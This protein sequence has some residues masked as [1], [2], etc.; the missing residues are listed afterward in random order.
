[1]RRDHCQG[2]ELRIKQKLHLTT[3]RWRLPQL[4]GSTVWGTSYDFRTMVEAEAESESRFRECKASPILAKRSSYPDEWW[5]GI[6]WILSRR[7][8]EIAAI[9][10]F[11]P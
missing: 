6:H 1:M 3:A 10:G 5:Q 11:A 2:R 8:V 4:A 7:W 9:L